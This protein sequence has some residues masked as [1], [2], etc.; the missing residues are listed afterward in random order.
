V[1]YLDH[2]W[3]AVSE[4]LFRASSNR[5]V[6]TSA[7]K[8]AQITRS[9]SGSGKN[10]RRQNGDCRCAYRRSRAEVGLGF[11]P[12]TRTANYDVPRESPPSLS[13]YTGAWEANY[14]PAGDISWCEINRL[15]L[16]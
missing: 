3:A 4:S 15:M 16:V 2:L 6:E 1:G 10:R 8:Q 11:A 14:D 7:R 12:C 9:S 13:R 5:A